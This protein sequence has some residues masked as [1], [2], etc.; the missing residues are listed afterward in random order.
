MTSITAR[1]VS[2]KRGWLLALAVA[3]AANVAVYVVVVRP[4]AASSAGAGERARDAALARAVAERQVASIEAQLTAEQQAGSDLRTFYG[5]ILPA[6]LTE[7]RRMT[8]ASLPALADR[9]GVRYQ[10]RRSDVEAVDADSRLQRM[11]IVMELMGEYGDLREFIYEVERADPFVVIDDV[12][13]T[14]RSEDE[15]PALVI[16]LSTYFAADADER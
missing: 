3:L 11:T 16:S 8:Y 10:R 15:P 9:T 6:S 4:L 13:L 14:E 2:E 12:T 5:E 1:V 7:A